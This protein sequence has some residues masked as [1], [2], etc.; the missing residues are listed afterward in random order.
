MGL[1]AVG[2]CR[3]LNPTGLVS[4]GEKRAEAQRGAAARR[5]RQRPHVLPPGLQQGQE[6]DLV[7]TCPRRPPTAVGLGVSLGPPWLINTFHGRVSWTL[8]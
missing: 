6:T 3:G 7:N 2:S 8:K 1:R 5:P 4:W